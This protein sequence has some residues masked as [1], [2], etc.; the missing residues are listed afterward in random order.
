MRDPTLRCSP[1]EPSSS[2]PAPLNS[3]LPTSTERIPANRPLRS[4]ATRPRFPGTPQPH[5]PA[6][7]RRVSGPPR[8]R[9]P[10][11]GRSLCPPSSAVVAELPGPIAPTSANESC[12]DRRPPPNFPPAA[13]RSPPAPRSPRL[14]V[15]ALC[16]GPAPGIVPSATHRGRRGRAPRPALAQR[17]PPAP[18]PP[19]SAAPWPGRVRSAPRRW[20]RR[21]E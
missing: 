8:D 4:R 11:G 5:P 1:V 16:P 2:R 14:P 9:E 19:L 15:A 21:S 20:T 7:R 12:G 18:C 3:S 10:G 6:E 13:S 17:R